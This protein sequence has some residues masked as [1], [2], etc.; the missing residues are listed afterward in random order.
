MPLDYKE[1]SAKIKSKYP[2][3][4]DVDDLTLAQKVIE[5]YP[6]YKDK[7]VFEPVKKKTIRNYLPFPLL[8]DRMAKI[9]VFP[10]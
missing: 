10:R 4:S 3:Y 9:L 2:E 5:K 6:E 8:W 7:V 1:F